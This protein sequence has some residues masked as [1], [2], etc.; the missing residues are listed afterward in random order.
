MSLRTQLRTLSKGS[1]STI[2]YIEKKRAIVDSLDE[3]LNPISIGDLIGHILNKINS[4][5]GLFT[6][7]L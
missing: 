3:D 4:S 7:S 5:Y 6:T 2:N 1:L